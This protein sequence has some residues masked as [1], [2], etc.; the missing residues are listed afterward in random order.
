MAKIVCAMLAFRKFAFIHFFVDIDIVL[1]GGGDGDVGF[2]VAI[3][4]QVRYCFG[5]WPLMQ[6][7]FDSRIV[8]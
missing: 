8:C 4:V 5:C 2:V 7:I 3:A 6:N 1:A